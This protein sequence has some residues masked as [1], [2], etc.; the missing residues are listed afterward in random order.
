MPH[1]RQAGWV[2]VGA[3]H[4]WPSGRPALTFLRAASSLLGDTRMAVAPSLTAA[5]EVLL[6]MRAVLQVP[7]VL[8]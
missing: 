4:G 8:V 6:A 7:L 5:P 3:E 1:G 2:L